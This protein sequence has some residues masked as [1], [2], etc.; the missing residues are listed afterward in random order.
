MFNRNELRFERRS[1]LT[2]AQLRA[3]EKFPREFLRL[4][5][6]DFGDGIL[7]GLDFVTRGKEIFLTAGVVKLGEKFFL[8]DEINLSTLIKNLPDGR[9][10]RFVLGAASRTATEGVIN[11]K[12]S[13]EVKPLDETSDGA[14]FGRFKAGLVNLP[15]INAQDL[16]KEF[17]R[18]SRLNLLHVPQAVRGGTTFH[19]T[20]FRAILSRLQRKENPSPADVALMLRLAD[21]E[22][23]SLPAL[24]IFVECKSVTWRD[25]SPEEIFK[26]VIAAVDA[27]Q[28]PVSPA[29]INKPEEVPAPQSTRETIWIQWR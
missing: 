27:V 2:A 16:Y 4:T 21:G 14:D 20:I 1:I 23:L 19:P 26:S 12:I 22:P 8:A 10:Y 6:A 11:E 25:A 7:S 3:I 28:E 17:T 13:L 5:F 9:K 15:D 29:Q 24:K 18:D